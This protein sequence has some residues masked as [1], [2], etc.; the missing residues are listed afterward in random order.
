MST[1]PGLILIVRKTGKAANGSGGKLEAG[2]GS[3]PF[4]E[5]HDRALSHVLDDVI[6]IFSG[7]EQRAEPQFVGA[8][9]SLRVPDRVIFRHIQ[10]FSEIEWGRLD[11]VATAPIPLP[12]DGRIIVIMNSLERQLEVSDRKEIA[13]KHPRIRIVGR[14]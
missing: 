2:N 5:P 4:V 13:V 12:A 14:S 10:A 1:Q 9:D 7:S 3:D 8:I 11:P 6:H